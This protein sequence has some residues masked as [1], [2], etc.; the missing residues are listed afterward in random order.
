MIFSLPIKRFIRKKQCFGLAIK[1]QIRKNTSNTLFLFHNAYEILIF[2]SIRMMLSYF[3]KTCS[4]ELY[5]LKFQ[6]PCDPVAYLDQ[7]YGAFPKWAKP[8]SEFSKYVWPSIVKNGHWTDKEYMS[9]VQIFK[10]NGKLSEVQ[11]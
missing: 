11:R 2:S 5:G 3:Q 7:N 10:G 9:A 4:A 8:Q 6:V 1:H